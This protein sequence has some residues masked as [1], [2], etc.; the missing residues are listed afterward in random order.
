MHQHK[1]SDAIPIMLWTGKLIPGWYWVD[2]QNT[3][4]VTNG[5]RQKATQL[6]NSPPDTIARMLLR[7]LESDSKFRSCD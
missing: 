4:I 1:P 2:E 5:R 3:V 6:G 7:D